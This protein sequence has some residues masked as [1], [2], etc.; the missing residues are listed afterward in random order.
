MNKFTHSLYRHVL[1]NIRC[2]SCNSHGSGAILQD[3]STPG[4]DFQE[5]MNIFILE[6]LATIIIHSYVYD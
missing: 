2:I 4:I 5:T 1:L 6:F 3:Q